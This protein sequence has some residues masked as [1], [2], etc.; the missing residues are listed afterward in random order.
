MLPG[1]VVMEVTSIVAELWQLL[2][3][4]PYCNY[5]RRFIGIIIVTYNLLLLLTRN[6]RSPPRN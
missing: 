4:L 5:Y 6:N 1:R 3:L 2:F